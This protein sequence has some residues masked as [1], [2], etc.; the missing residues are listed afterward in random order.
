MNMILNCFLLIRNYCAANKP[1]NMTARYQIL[2]LVAHINQHDGEY[3]AFNL[4]WNLAT[5]LL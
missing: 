3:I 2:F 1:G 4:H 5:S